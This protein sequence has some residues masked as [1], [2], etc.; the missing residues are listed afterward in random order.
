MPPYEQTTC[1]WDAWHRGSHQKV[2]AFSFYSVPSR[3]N[4]SSRY[5]KG[6]KANLD[7]M[8]QLYKKEWNMRLYHDLEVEDPLMV[9]A[10]HLACNNSRLDL[11]PVK[12]LLH[13]LL[14]NASNIFPMNWRFFPTLDSQ[15]L[16]MGSRDLDSR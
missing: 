11:C 5:F 7:L 9:D 2:L 12:K 16:E 8:G 14:A 10:C 1:S 13:P 4:K 15:V 6:V 3:A